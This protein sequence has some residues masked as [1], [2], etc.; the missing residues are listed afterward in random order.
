MEND[1]RTSAFA[2]SERRR[3][4]RCVRHSDRKVGLER[5]A[6]DESIQSWIRFAPTG[7]R[8]EGIRA[9]GARPLGLRKASL[10][11]LARE[12]LGEEPALQVLDFNPW[13]FSGA[14]QLVEVFFA[15][16][17]AQLRLKSENFTVIA[18]E[19]DSYARLLTPLSVLPFVGAW[20]D[21]TARATEA[22]NRFAQSARTLL[23]SARAA[24]TQQV[25]GR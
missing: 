5:G 24:P 4:Y 22:V 7:G 19:I 2:P 16:L 17:S 1:E 14:E 12:A 20:A 3:A 10:I 9:G 18:D 15:E 23:A 6:R 11:N 21:R 25:I 13:M 8:L